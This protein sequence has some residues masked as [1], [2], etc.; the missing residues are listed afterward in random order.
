M[1]LSEYFENAKGVGVLATA[2]AEGKVNTAIYSR[3]HFLKPGDD[4]TITFIM[5]DRLCHANVQINP[6]ASYLFIEEGEG[7]VGKRLSLTK[8]GEETDQ[9]K[10]QAIR[11]RNL[12]CEC[13]EGKTR[14]LV[15]FRIDGIRPLIGTDSE[16]TCETP[17]T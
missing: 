16:E 2:D 13:E 1:K 14:F 7:Y 9:E 5:A 17:V 8:V 3:P 6:R 11:R 4:D 12:P 15:H 10:I